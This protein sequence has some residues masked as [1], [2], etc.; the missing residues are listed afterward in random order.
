MSDTVFDENFLPRLLAAI[1]YFFNQL[2]RRWYL[3]LIFLLF[4]L[5]LI[6]FQQIFLWLL[7]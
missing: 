5:I 4:L 3:G 7:Y 2:R 6:F 1:N